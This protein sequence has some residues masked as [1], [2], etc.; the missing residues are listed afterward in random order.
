MQIVITA[1][2]FKNFVRIVPIVAFLNSVFTKHFS[3]R[4]FSKM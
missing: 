1:P 4:L 3:P 2:S